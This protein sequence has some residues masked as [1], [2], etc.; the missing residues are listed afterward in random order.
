MATAAKS[1]ATAD[2]AGANA[3]DIEA[4]LARVREDIAALA[5]SIQSYGT[6]KTDEVKS[7]ASKAGNDIAA[8]SQDAL[9]QVRREF[10]GLESQLQGQVRRHPLQAL[11]I[12]AGIGFLAAFLMRR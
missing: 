8:A 9:E 5:R 4:E 2:T 1:T 3:Q 12:A 11:G 10:E 7:R 6:A